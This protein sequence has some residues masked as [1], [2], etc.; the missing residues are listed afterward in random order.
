MKNKA[1]V[2]IG[3]RG[4]GSESRMYITI[5]DES[6]RTRI[7]EVSMSLEDFA[8][9]LTGLASCG[10]TMESVVSPENVHKLG[11]E[12]VTQEVFVEKNR[13]KGIQSLIVEKD[14]IENW[15]EDGWEIFNDGL[16]SQQHGE[17]HRYV[18]RRWV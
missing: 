4:F 18:I 12:C 3:K 6:S 8:Q 1:E 16:R 15:Q 14:F 13:K 17:L 7:V 10:G 11:K 9:A 2:T 5:T